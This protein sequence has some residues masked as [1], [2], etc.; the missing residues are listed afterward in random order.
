MSD[1]NT[2]PEVDGSENLDDFFGT[3]KSGSDMNWKMHAL[4]DGEVNIFR[5]AP[6]VKSLKTVG[7]WKLYDKLHYG[8]PTTRT[9]TSP[10]TSP[11]AASRRRTGPPT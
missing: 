7:K 5:I 2:N 10:G 6:P 8:Y 9:P 4:K 1:N 3:A 11:S